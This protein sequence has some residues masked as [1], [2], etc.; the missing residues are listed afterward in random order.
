M[1]LRDEVPDDIA[2]IRALIAAAFEDHPHSDQREPRIVEALRS[3]GA[4]SLALVAEMDGRLVGFVGFSPVRIDGET[5]RWF[6]LGPL[7]VEP[8]RQSAGVGKALVKYGLARLAEIGAAGCVVLGEPA[9]Y[10]RFGFVADPRL[11]MPGPPAQYFQALWL[12][13]APAQGEVT[14]DRAFFDA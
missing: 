7:A 13:A 1:I 4:L 11:R 12:K 8:E 14:Y 6:G 3:S 9:Y 5:G 2:H 10:G